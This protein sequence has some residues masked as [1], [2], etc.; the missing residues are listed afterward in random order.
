MTQAS[1]ISAE[2]KAILDELGLDIERMTATVKALS[3]LIT[4][5]GPAHNVKPEEM[6][7]ALTF[8]AEQ[9]LVALG[10]AAKSLATG[11]RC[12]ALGIGQALEQGDMQ[13]LFSAGVMPASAIEDAKECPGCPECSD[14]VSVH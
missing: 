14:D 2:D 7:H 3:D 4:E 5:Y 11:K 10:D 9:S 1:E 8:L 6:T 12:M 13:T